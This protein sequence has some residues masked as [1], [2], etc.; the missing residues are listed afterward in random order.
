MTQMQALLK[1]LQADAFHASE[2]TDLPVRGDSPW[3]HEENPMGV[4]SWSQDENEVII[5]TCAADYRI[6]SYA[7]AVEMYQRR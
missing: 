2:L 5:G 4:W 6:V 7:V 3:G 1:A